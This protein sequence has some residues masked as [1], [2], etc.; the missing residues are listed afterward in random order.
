M[1]KLERTWADL[2][3]GLIQFACSIRTNLAAIAAMFGVD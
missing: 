3:A 1:Q 2:L